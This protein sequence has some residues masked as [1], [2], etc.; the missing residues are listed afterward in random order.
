[1]DTNDNRNNNNL[2]AFDCL[3]FNKCSLQECLH[4]YTESKNR[5]RNSYITKLAQ[6]KER[7]EARAALTTSTYQHT[8]SSQE[9]DQLLSN[10]SRGSQYNYDADGSDKTR[11]SL[12]MT[13]HF[14]PGNSTTCGRLLYELGLF[15]N[16]K[17]NKLGK[18]YNPVLKL[19]NTNESINEKR[20]HL[21]TLPSKW[22]L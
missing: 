15:N 10:R 2:C 12:V 4:E 22:L 3:I 14:D 8:M 9:M 5:L 16:D 11:L 19:I 20:H 21:K 17:L 6:A 1:M 13:D 18:E 7:R